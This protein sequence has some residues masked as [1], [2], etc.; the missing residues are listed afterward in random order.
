MQMFTLLLVF[1]SYVVDM[2]AS[3]I[4]I[5]LFYLLLRL[6]NMPLLYG[7]ERN[8]EYYLYLTYETIVLLCTLAFVSINVTYM[9]SIQARLSQ[10]MVEN[11]NLLNKMNEGLI[12][13]SEEN[14][15][16]QFANCSA[17]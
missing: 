2:L 13:V 1:L 5:T 4:S 15:T 14:N 8:S 7:I 10:L 16:L 3:M 12:V 9:T 17:R 11:K 6:Y